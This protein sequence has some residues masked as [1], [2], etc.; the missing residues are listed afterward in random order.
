MDFSL[1]SRAAMA[2]LGYLLPTPEVY[3]EAEHSGKVKELLKKKF[4]TIQ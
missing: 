3:F 4:S 2:H 1:Q